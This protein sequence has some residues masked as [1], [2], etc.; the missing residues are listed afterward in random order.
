[1]YRAMHTTMNTHTHHPMHTNTYCTAAGEAHAHSHVHKCFEHAGL[2]MAEGVLDYTK[3]GAYAC[4][5]KTHMPAL[6]NV[7][8]M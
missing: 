3:P 4:A 1:M 6:V 7:K 8:L 2:S 5:S